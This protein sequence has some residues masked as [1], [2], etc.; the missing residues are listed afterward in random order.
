VPNIRLLGK[1]WSDCPFEIYLTNEL[2][3]Q[4]RIGKVNLMNLGG[5]LDWSSLLIR[6]LKV[7]KT[8]Y[9]L[10]TLDDFLLRKKVNTNE[11]LDLLAT[12]DSSQINMMRLIPRPGPDYRLKNID[13][14]GA[15]AINAQYRV[16]TQASLWKKEVLLKI[17]QNGESPWEFEEKGTERAKTI[18]N[19]YCV[20]ES[21]YPYYH[22]AIQRG[23][24]FPWDAVFFKRMNI[25]VNLKN[26]KI[27]SS[28]EVLYY[29]LRKIFDVV[30]KIFPNN[31]IAN[32]KKLIKKC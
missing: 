25:E 5:G 19:F 17:L 14:Y 30:V 24:W 9:V 27:M 3:S 16:S 28:Y 2:Y 10:F 26:R 8:D 15:I 18:P 32:I 12:M 4:S 6:A 21:P 7:L 22:H 11:I 1:Y 13:S 29:I 23:K 31:F 20:W